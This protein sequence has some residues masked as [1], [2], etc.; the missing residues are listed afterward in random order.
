[1][2]LSQLGFHDSSFIFP[3]FSIIN[4]YLFIYPELPKKDTSGISTALFT[5]KVYCNFLK[6][7][8]QPQKLLSLV[9]VP[10]RN[11]ADFYINKVMWL[12]NC[13]CQ[14]TEDKVSSVWTISLN[15]S[16]LSWLLSSHPT[17]D[18]INLFQASSVR[19]TNYQGIFYINIFDSPPHSPSPVINK[20]GGIFVLSV[21]SLEFPQVCAK[22]GVGV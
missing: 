12:S 17:F 14:L 11:H 22:G 13:L 8:K 9:Y 1:M 4:R 16:F 15:T 3:W 6:E 2:V 21:N 7:R 19:F 10:S 18:N 5:K 20:K